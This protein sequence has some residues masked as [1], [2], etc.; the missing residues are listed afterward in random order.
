MLGSWNT[1]TDLSFQ[2]KRPHFQVDKTRCSFQAGQFLQQKKNHLSAQ[3]CQEQI[4][5]LRRDVWNSS[6]QAPQGVKVDASMG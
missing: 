1:Q 5:I 6:H 2:E 3:R 4:H